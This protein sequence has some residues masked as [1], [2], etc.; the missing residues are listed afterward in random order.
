MGVITLNGKTSTSIGLQVEIPPDYEIPERI[1]EPIH[2]PGRNGDIVMDTGAYAN[3]ERIYQISIG[4]SNGDFSTM[5]NNISQWLHSAPGYIRLEDT[6]E[7][8][9]YKLVRYGEGNSII[10]I[11]Q[12]AGRATLTFDRKP[13]RFLKTGETAITVNTGSATIN[14]PTNFS[15]KPLIVVNGTGPGTI[16]IGDYII[17]ITQLS[18]YMHIDCE[19]E[20]AFKGAINMNSYISL[21]KDDFPVLEPGNTVVSYTGSIT[22]LV[23]TPRWWTI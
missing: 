9:Y 2:V 10:N 7:P 5:A 20:D 21:N 4:D 15:S 18:S 3:V 17:S 16:T 11:L 6:Y 13:Q 14:N 8:N 23:I 12:Q 19:V 1:Y 22:S